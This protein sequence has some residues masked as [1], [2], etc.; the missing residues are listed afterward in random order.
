MYGSRCS[1]DHRALECWIW[2]FSNFENHDLE[3]LIG[4]GNPFEKL[5]STFL[6]TEGYHQKNV[7]ENMSKQG[8]AVQNKKLGENL[9]CY[10][11]SHERKPQIPQGAY[12]LW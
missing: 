10:Y 12:S 7:P 2:F 3:Y 9:E 11:K 1:L 8:H 4:N 5:G 6:Y